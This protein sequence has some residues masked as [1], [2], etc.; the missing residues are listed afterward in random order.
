MTFVL[1]QKC[2]PKLPFFKIHYWI[3]FHHHKIDAGEPS[4]DK[5]TLHLR[6]VYPEL[7][8]VRYKTNAIFKQIKQNIMVKCMKVKPIFEI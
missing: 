1:S 7:K 3:R 5:A 6:G 8:G 4:V 2:I